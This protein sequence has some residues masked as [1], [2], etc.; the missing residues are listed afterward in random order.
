MWIF[1]F[2]AICSKFLEEWHCGAQ[3]RPHKKARRWQNSL[4]GHHQIQLSVPASHRGSLASLDDLHVFQRS[5]S[6]CSMQ[7]DTKLETMSLNMEL[8]SSPSGKLS[9]DGVRLILDQLW[10]TLFVYFKFYFQL[11]I[12]ILW[13][14][15]YESE[16][17]GIKNIG[18][19]N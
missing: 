11:K 13:L 9:D 1:M 10:N 15:N 17:L 3:L 19:L 4:S 16:S 5:R 8:F 6:M 2:I 18:I 7:L 14:D 12:F